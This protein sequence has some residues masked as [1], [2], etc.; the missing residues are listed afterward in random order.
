MAPRFLSPLALTASLMLVACSSAPPRAEVAAAVPEVRPGVP[1][2]Y[3]PRS[4]IPDS[5]ALV[6]PPPQSGSAAFAN[7]EAVHAAAATLRG[8]AR[9]QQATEDANLDFPRAAGTFSCALG[10]PVNAKDTPRLLL[11]LRRTLMDAARA[12]ETAKKHYQRTRPFVF[13]QEPTCTPGDEA[14]LATN[15]SYPS[16]H[17][18]IGWAWALILTTAAPERSEQI[19][20]RGRSYG[21]S[22]L[23]CNVH[24]QSDVL[25]GR[26]LG[27]GIVARLHADPRF[28]ED[29]VA[30]TAEI[31]AARAANLQPDRDC[32]AEAAALTQRLPGA[33]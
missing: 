26:F 27:A 32:A 9:W 14:A 6:P 2:G 19:L 13:H 20:A 29:L 3:L 18:S 25:A 8:S 5:M 23:V 7:D 16:G 1:D 15:G 11:L 22:R 30:A 28:R 17:T 12:P 10:V 31:A 24:W 21:E 33:L 4:A